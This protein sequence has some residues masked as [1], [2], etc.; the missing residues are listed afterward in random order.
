MNEEKVILERH[1]PI[2]FIVNYNN[3]RVV[4]RGSKGKMIDRKEVS[5]DLFDFLAMSTRAISDGALV[6][7]NKSE[8]KKEILD[9]LVDREAYENNALT[10]EEAI[11]LLRGKFEVM[12]NSFDKVTSIDTKTFIYEVA[13]EIKLE[14]AKK[15][16]YIKE[17]LGSELSTE[18]LFDEE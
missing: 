8:N 1:K 6:I 13:K 3:K 10:K 4:W 12:K 17:M 14:S 18:E 7:S 16:K 15:Q 2:D 11:K 5:R 9:E